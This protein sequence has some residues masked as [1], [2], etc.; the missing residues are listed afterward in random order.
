MREFWR[1]IPIFHRDIS[2]RRDAPQS[3][4]LL[5][6]SRKGLDYVT[7]SKHLLARWDPLLAKP[8]R[9]QSDRDLDL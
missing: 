9:P 4:M 1:V 5:R 2:A 7:R 6:H 3:R 8:P